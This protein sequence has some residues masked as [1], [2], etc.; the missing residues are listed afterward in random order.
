MTN[1]NIIQIFQTTFAGAGIPELSVLGDS[2]HERGASVEIAPG[3]KDC[4]H[5][6]MDAV[7]KLEE[8]RGHGLGASNPVVPGGEDA[9]ALDDHATVSISIMPGFHRLLH[10]DFERGLVF[11]EEIGHRSFPCRTIATAVVFVDTW[12]AHDLY[13]FVVDCVVKFEAP[14][15]L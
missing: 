1:T 3:T 9:L 11:C 2:D 13:E 6:G 15:R 14:G 4:V 10:G 5:F 12:R 8:P 7:G